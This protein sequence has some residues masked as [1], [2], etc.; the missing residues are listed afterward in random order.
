M[1]HDFIPSMWRLLRRIHHMGATADNRHCA[2]QCPR[3]GVYAAF[4]SYS[5]TSRS[6]TNLKVR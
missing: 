3:A 2:L 1:K 4:V 6:L 5:D